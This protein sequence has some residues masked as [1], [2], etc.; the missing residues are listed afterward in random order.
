[1]NG[2]IRIS[3]WQRLHRKHQP[4]ESERIIFRALNRFE[5][6]RMGDEASQD[7]ERHALNVMLVIC[8][9]PSRP[10]RIAV[11]TLPEQLAGGDLG[12]SRRA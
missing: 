5:V 1:V 8:T 3:E 2:C 7:F 9:H 12:G 11:I 6:V 4:A 10:H